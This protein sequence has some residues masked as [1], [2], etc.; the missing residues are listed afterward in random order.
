MFLK[1]IKNILEKEPSY[2]L[3]QADK[4]IFKHLIGDWKEATIFSNDLRKKL[5]EDCPL[6]IKAKLFKE[7]KDN[8]CKALI[9]LE[10]GN[11]I[12]TVLMRHK[13]RNTICLSSQ[14]GCP[15]SCVFCATGKSGFRRNL[16]SEEIILQALYWGRFLKSK[17]KNINNVVF[18]GMGEP[19]LNYDEV[20]KAIRILNDKDK[21]NIGARRISIS[22]CGIPEGIRKLMRENKQINLALSLHAPNDRLRSY[23]MPINKEY[24]INK[25]LGALREYIKTSNRKVMIEY[26]MLDGVNDSQDMAREL[27]RL[28]KDKLKNLYFV[29]L[30]AYNKSAE[31]ADKTGQFRSS[32]PDQINKFK[33]ILE[34]SGITVV[35]RY[36]FGRDIK[37]ACGQLAGDG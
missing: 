29:N 6:E 11:A 16:N 9:Y 21:F 13:K 17:N 27:A 15:M 2:R 1:S 8:A 32:S 23:L 33:R 24:S 36:R 26:V 25:I 28:L 30:I 12:E 5:N 20:I 37:G 10:D 22:T 34:D 19:L 3:K 18:M 35:E 31:E 4:A 7:N 14:V